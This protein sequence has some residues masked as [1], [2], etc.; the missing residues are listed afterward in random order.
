MYFKFRM[1]QT[2]QT[3]F[4]FLQP[5]KENDA[6]AAHI[7]QTLSTGHFQHISHHLNNWSEI[8]FPGVFISY[9]MW[10]SS[11]NI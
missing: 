5:I 4:F 9:I 6:H 8:K 7:V 2:F 11:Q 1:F 10:P 3:G